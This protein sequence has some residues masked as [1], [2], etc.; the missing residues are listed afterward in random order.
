MIEKLKDL[1]NRLNQHGIS[2]PLFRDPKSGVASVSLTMMFI[3]FTLCCVGLVGKASG[4]LGGVDL[5]QALTLLGLTSSLYFA[6]NYN[7][8]TGA[9]ENVSTDLET[10]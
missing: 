5:S 2:I 4:F 6:R 8:K 9:S 10:K 7:N 3:S 1:A